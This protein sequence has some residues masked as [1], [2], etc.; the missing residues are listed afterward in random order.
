METLK[1]RE[2]SIEVFFFEPDAIVGN[3][4]SA[5]WP[6]VEFRMSGHRG[7]D[8]R[9]PDDDSQRHVRSSKLQRVADEVLQKLAYLR[10]IGL[11]TWQQAD[12]HVG[13]SLFN[14]H[15]QIS[16][17]L[18]GDGGEFDLLPASRARRHSRERKEVVDQRRHASRGALHSLQIVP[19]IV[20]QG[21]AETLLEAT[22]KGAY[23][24]QGLLQI[25][26][27]DVCKLLQFPV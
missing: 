9:G 22:A 27:R 12:V 24:A 11:D 13:S 15:F 17:H 5:V 7:F 8:Q 14:L 21:V 2:N 23:L 19:A 20:G 4:Q 6:L 25:M 16:K 10:R 18:T 3:L 26:R 1:D